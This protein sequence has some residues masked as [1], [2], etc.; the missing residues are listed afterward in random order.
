[1]DRETEKLDSVNIVP[2][3][4]GVTEG[5]VQALKIVLREIL[6]EELKDIFTLESLIGCTAGSAEQQ[7]LNTVSYIT[8]IHMKDAT[9]KAV[10]KA[11]ENSF[12]IY[13]RVHG[14]ERELIE[15]V[16]MECLHRFRGEL[17]ENIS[18]TPIYH[19]TERNPE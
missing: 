15:K 18:K 10:D 6:R 2:E 19:K 17:I 16:V 5:H 11:L 7:I 12:D 8:S 1:M 9:A 3:E 4:H 13:R 14:L